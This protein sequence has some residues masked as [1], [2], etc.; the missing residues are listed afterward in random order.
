[1][2]LNTTSDTTAPS[3]TMMPKARLV[4]LMV[5]LVKRMRRKSALVSVPIFSAQELDDSVQLLTDMSSQ[6]SERPP[7]RVVFRQMASSPVRIMQSETSTRLQPSMSSPSEFTPRSRLELM[8]TPR[9]VTSWLHCR[10]QLQLGEFSMCTSR[11]ATLRQPEMYT[12]DTFGLR[13]R[14]AFMSKP[15]ASAFA[16]QPGYASG[17]VTGNVVKRGSPSRRPG[18]VR[19]T[20]VTSLATIN[21]GIKLSPA[22]SR[23]ALSLR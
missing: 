10:W 15:A 21:A 18:P 19:P 12:S 2:L 17:A 13:T 4:S 22:S 23:P 9:I 11:N 7:W 8:C 1:M 5:Q 6:V 14:K 20:L 3:R 16:V